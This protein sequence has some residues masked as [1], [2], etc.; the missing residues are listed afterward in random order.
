MC[1]LLQYH[2]LRVASS[3]RHLGY[4]LSFSP[5]DT[6]Q[7]R[8]R[9]RTTG[10]STTVWWS[11]SRKRD[12]CSIYA[13]A[14]F[15]LIICILIRIFYHDSPQHRLFSSTKYSKHPAFHPSASTPPRWPGF[16]RQPVKNDIIDGTDWID[17]LWAV[18][19]RTGFYRS[20]G[21]F[22]ST[23]RKLGEHAARYHT[24]RFSFIW[25]I[26]RS[27]IK[28]NTLYQDTLKV[29]VLDSSTTFSKK[30]VATAQMQRHSV[31]TFVVDARLLGQN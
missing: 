23:S 31:T 6:I 8:Y 12:P 26:I 1:F 13:L 15:N 10:C 22:V 17:V 25:F 29:S 7:L 27:H 21:C 24:F 16:Y 11:V 9:H 5:G 2:H 4:H 19:H 3:K 14:L 30:S 20:T 28:T 18:L